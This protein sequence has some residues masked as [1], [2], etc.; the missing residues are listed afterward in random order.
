MDAVDDIRFVKTGPR[1]VSVETVL[2]ES[3]TIH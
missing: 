2:I 1:D 3:V